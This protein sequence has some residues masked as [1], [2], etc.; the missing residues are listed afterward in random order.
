MRVFWSTV[1]GIVLVV[2]IVYLAQGQQQT[3]ADAG[4]DPAAAD[5]AALGPAALQT[6]K[7]RLSYFFGVIIARKII[8]E[9]LDI[10]PQ[11]MDMGLQ[12]VLTRAP[13]KLDQQQMQQAQAMYNQHLQQ[14]MARIAKYNKEEGD[15]VLAANRE[16]PDITELPS[17][18]QYQVIK[19]GTGPKPTGADKVKVHFRAL[20]LDEKRTF[21]S[22]YQRGLP[23]TWL[24]N[25]VTIPGLKTVLPMMPVGSQWKLW[26]PP[27]QGAGSGPNAVIVFEI[28]LTEIVA[29]SSE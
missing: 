26:L 18:V 1:C 23:L 10:N 27:D 7:D 6:D 8:T 4:A 17:G 9:G 12:D 11:A 2:G 22:T 24:V 19:E 25:N 13:L 28:E 15:K 16:N 3:Q 29:P 20:S 5:A 14:R 21:Q